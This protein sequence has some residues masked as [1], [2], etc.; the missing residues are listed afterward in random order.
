MALPFKFEHFKKYIDSSHKTGRIRRACFH[1]DRSLGFPLGQT[2][3][4]KAHVPTLSITFDLFA[5]SFFVSLLLILP[6]IYSPALRGHKVRRNKQTDIK[7]K[8][9]NQF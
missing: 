8:K 4:F 7:V 1:M 3:S 6:R 5:L 9:E 2:S